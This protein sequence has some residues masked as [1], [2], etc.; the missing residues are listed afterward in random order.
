[1]I[2][3]CIDYFLSDDGVSENEIDP[4]VND[5][6]LSA[7]ALD[8]EARVLLRKY[9]GDLFEAGRGDTAEPTMKEF[10]SRKP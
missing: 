7:V 10:F 6:V 3:R 5:D 4:D 9:M 2:L 1:M 8:R